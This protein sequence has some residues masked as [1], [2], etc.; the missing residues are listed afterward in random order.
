M[1]EIKRIFSRKY[2][3]ILAF[4][5]IA[6]ATN[7]KN[8]NNTTKL[9]IH[10]ANGIYQGDLKETE[11]FSNYDLSDSD[12]ILTLYNKTYLTMLENSNDTN[13][14][15]MPENPLSIDLENVTLTTSLKSISMPF[16]TIFLDQIIGFSI[17]SME[18]QD[19]EK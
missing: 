17:G 19:R 7:E 15:K 3:K 16:V 2:L 9:L 13:L 5:T 6:K 18:Q 11:E 10:T 4:D 1:A 14:E 8:S 12:D